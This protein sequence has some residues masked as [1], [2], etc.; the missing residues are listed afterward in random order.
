MIRSTHS[1]QNRSYYSGHIISSEGVKHDPK[2]IEAVQCFPQ[3]KN[4]KNIKQ[5]LGLAGYYRRFIKDFSAIAK[6]LPKF[7]KKEEVFKWGEEEEE[8]FKILRQ[9]LCNSPILQYPDFSKPCTVTTDLSG[10]AIGAVLSQEVQNTDLPVACLSRALT[11][12]E[13]NYSTTK[14]EFLAV[15]YAITKLRPYLYG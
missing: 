12:P 4:P 11:E 1:L 6:P 3:P 2:N 15:L 10:F 5:F 9:A 14:K 8:S 7:F 13:L